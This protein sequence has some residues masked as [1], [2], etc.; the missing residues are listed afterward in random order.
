MKKITAKARQYFSDNY[1]ASLMNTPA[2]AYTYYF[3]FCVPGEL[4]ILSTE[5]YMKVMKEVHEE[6]KLSLE[7]IKN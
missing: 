3:L 2:S 1:R 4:I 5:G 7:T 6:K